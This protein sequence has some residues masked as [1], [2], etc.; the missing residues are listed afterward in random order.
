MAGGKK[1]EK[2]DGEKI[3]AE[4][5]G[6]ITNH[7]NNGNDGLT[8]AK[9]NDAVLASANNK[10]V[11]TKSK[12]KGANSEEAVV[13]AVGEKFNN[14]VSEELTSNNGDKSSSE[15]VNDGKVSVEDKKLSASSNKMALKSLN[16]TIKE[17]LKGASKLSAKEKKEI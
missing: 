6:N 11:L 17:K 14:E 12:K 1:S 15:D 13:S 5:S 7:I 4:E 10:K 9:Q 2:S 16:K 3:L 8:N